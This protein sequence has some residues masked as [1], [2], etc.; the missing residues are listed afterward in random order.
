MPKLFY[1]ARY[2]WDVLL[3]RHGPL[4][5]RQIIGDVRSIYHAP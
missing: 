3:R 1:C 4:T 2:L 5:L